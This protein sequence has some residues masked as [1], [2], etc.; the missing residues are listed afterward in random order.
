M[1]SCVDAN[2]FHHDVFNLNASLEAKHG[3]R[4]LVI[5]LQ[6]KLGWFGHSFSIVEVPVAKVGSLTVLDGVAK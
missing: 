1:L 5:S 3:M 6:L 4:R 2:C